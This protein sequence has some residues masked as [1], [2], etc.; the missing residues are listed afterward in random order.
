MFFNGPHR[1]VT[2]DDAVG[3]SLGNDKKEK[4][5]GFQRALWMGKK[6]S[7]NKKSKL[8]IPADLSP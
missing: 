1:P 7:L 6:P 2:W 3:R 8:P 5:L 4:E